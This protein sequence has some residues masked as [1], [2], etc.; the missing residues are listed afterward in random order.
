MHQQFN[1][2]AYLKLMYLTSWFIALIV[3]RIIKSVSQ[4][5]MIIIF[6]PSLS[7]PLVLRHA[8]QHQRDPEGEEPEAVPP[9]PALSGPESDAS[10][11]PQPLP[12]CASQL[13]AHT[14]GRGSESERQHLLQPPAAA[15]RSVCWR[16][17]VFLKSWERRRQFTSCLVWI[18]MFTLEAL[19]AS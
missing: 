7:V 16:A 5:N 3:S 18:V 4:W 12:V 10:T 2:M 15:H 19:V 9:Q 14:R 13:G 1:W 11:Q 17:D 6:S 8:H